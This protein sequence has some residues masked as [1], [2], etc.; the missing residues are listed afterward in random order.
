MT[1][2]L[3][4]GLRAINDHLA[5]WRDAVR[6]LPLRGSRQRARLREL[7]ARAN[8][9]AKKLSEARAAV[10]HALALIH[11]PNTL[12]EE[13]AAM[14]KPQ[15]MRSTLAALILAVLV[16]AC[17]DEPLPEVCPAGQPSLDLEGNEI[18]LY[19]Q[20]PGQFCR[21]DQDCIGGDVDEGFCLTFRQ[22]CATACDI[23][24]GEAECAEL[25]ED[26]ALKCQSITGRNLCSAGV[27]RN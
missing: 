8:S 18:P 15:P 23:T 7:E 22:Q 13:E 26:P 25:Y 1:T 16:P 21:R 14:S 6:G 17:D 3:E 9:A 12:E 10:E 2:D 5:R 19:T 11:D 27:E 4:H 20:P 24:Q